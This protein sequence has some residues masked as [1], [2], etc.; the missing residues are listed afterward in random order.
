MQQTTQPSIKAGVDLT[1][2]RAVLGPVLAAHGVELVDLEWLPQPSGWTLRLTIERALCDGGPPGKPGSAPK[3]PSTEAEGGVTLEDCV[4]VSRDAS[5][6]LDVEDIIVPRYQLE[7]S[8]PGLDRPLRREADF[9]RF[10]GR[11]ARVKLARPAPDGQR[12]LRGKLDAAP[13]GA[14]AVLIEAAGGALR[15]RIEVP[16]TDVVEANLVFELTPQPKKGARQG[17]APHGKKPGGAK[18]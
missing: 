6:V 18:Q 14:V 9:V 4:E 11:T 16:F 5:S 13:E 15:K 10:R 3:P 12:V 2:V 17:K 7:V 8:S 1:R